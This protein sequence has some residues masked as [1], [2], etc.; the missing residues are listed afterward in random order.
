MAVM[1]APCR[2]C[3]RLLRIVCH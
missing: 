3:E 1:I 2:R